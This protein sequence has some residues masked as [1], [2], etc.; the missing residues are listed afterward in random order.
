MGD[1]DDFSI[2]VV[3]KDSGSSET[4]FNEFLISAT[5]INLFFMPFVIK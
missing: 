4:L 3:R 1:D 2:Y 5:V